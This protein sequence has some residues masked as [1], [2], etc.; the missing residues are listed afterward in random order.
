MQ[1]SHFLR[2]D[3]VNSTHLLGGIIAERQS[4]AGCIL[5]DVGVTLE[6]ALPL[7]ARANDTVLPTEPWT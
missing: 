6:R 5:A 7:L 3:E 1:L 4:L 2:N